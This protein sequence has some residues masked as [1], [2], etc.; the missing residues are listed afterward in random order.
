MDLTKL[1]TDLH[2]ERDAFLGEHGLENFGYPQINGFQLSVLPPWRDPDP[3]DILNVELTS[4]GVVCL[5]TQLKGIVL[6]CVREDD[7][8]LHWELPAGG[9]ELS[10]S[11]IV[12]TARR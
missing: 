8:S 9:V 6:V 2:R 1:A 5:S 12:C 11:S 10:D 3:E 7:G 4:A